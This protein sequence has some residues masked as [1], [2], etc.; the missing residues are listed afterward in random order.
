MPTPRKYASS[1]ER[2]AAHRRRS[3]EAVAALSAA[4]GLPAVSP[5]TTLPSIRRWQALLHAASHAL[6]SARDEMQVYVENRSEG[7]QDSQKAEEMQERIQ[8]IEAA[9]DALQSITWNG[10]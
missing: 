5:V 10:Q 4:K 6:E 1:A 3:R 7:W 8:A 9:M 2:Q